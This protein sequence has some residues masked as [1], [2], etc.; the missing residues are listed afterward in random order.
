M[1]LTAS[2]PTPALC[3][4]V[5]PAKTR[6]GGTGLATCPQD[7]STSATT[8][9]CS[10]PTKDYDAASCEGPRNLFKDEEKNQI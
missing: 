2:A 6:G 10:E 3:T 8:A 7:K 1:R 4:G 9:A 5:I